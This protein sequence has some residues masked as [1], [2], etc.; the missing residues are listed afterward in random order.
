MSG[1]LRL[2]RRDDP[3]LNY[4]L[5]DFVMDYDFRRMGGACEA[6]SL[7]RHGGAIVPGAMPRANARQ[8]FSLKLT[9]LLSRGE[10]AA[11]N[12]RL[13][14]FTCFFLSRNSQETQKRV[15]SLPGT[16]G[17]TNLPTNYYLLTTNYSKEKYNPNII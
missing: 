9:T 1:R 11:A 16:S 13:I 4:D 15:F 8:A 2:C 17:T 6:E 10:G 5:C 12:H 7:M 14:G 3:C